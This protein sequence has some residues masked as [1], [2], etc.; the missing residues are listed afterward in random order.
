M[1]A[2]TATATARVRQDIVTQLGLKHPATFQ[3]SF[4]RANLF[5]RVH[6]KRGAYQELTAYLKGQPDASGI[7]YCLS[8]SNT[9]ELAARLKSD[10][11]DAASYHA[12]LDN[13]VR[14][15]RQEAFIRDDL[16]IIVAT[17]AFGMGIDKPD[18]RFVVH[19]DVPKNLEGYYQESGRAGRDGEPAD[20][21]LFYAYED[22]LKHEYFIDQKPTLQEQEVAR[23]QLYDM[24]RWAETGACRRADLLAYFGEE[25]AGHTG[26]C[27]DNC[28]H[29]PEQKDYTVAAQKLLS[30]AR[31]TGERYGAT[32]LINVLLGSKERAVLNA[33][34]DE[35]PT[36]GVGRDLSR[37]EWRHVIDG[38]ARAGVLRIDRENYSAI[39]VTPAG[40]EVLFKGRKIAFAAYRSR[41][42]GEQGTV[43]WQPNGT[44]F[45][46]L[47]ALRKRIADEH[48]VPPYIIFHDRVLWEMAAQ[49]PANLRQLRRI[50]GIGERKLVDFGEQFLGAIA[51]YVRRTGTQSSGGK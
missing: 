36:Y 37:E 33:R 19:Y 31:R 2:L 18:V 12:G 32:H 10:G 14:R 28:E 1:A 7:I 25:L 49:L 39:K 22:A 46:E 3:G 45:E 40:A 16:R 9:E 27:C 42:G 47:R 13:E 6:P 41:R 5:Y 11:F 48:G 38:L 4:N 24:V 20:C 21:L 29:P 43:D 50:P 51:A 35:L 17:I 15:K 8:R 44:L 34:H 23:R 26:P 30:C